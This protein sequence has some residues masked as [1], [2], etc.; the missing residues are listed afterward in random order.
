MVMPTNS[1]T[2]ETSVEMA[3]PT[4]PQRGISQKFSPTFTAAPTP[5]TTQ[6]NCV[7]RARPLPMAS[8]V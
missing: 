2:Y 5:V 6:L 1:T 3:A 7:L 8:T 4:I